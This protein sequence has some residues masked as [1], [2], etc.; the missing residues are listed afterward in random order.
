MIERANNRAGNGELVNCDDCAGLVVTLANLLG[1]DLYEQTVLT[2]AM[3]PVIPIGEGQWWAHGLGFLPASGPTGVGV[4]TYHRVAWRGSNENDALVFDI[5]WLLNAFADPDNPEQPHPR[6]A[7]P[8]MRMESGSRSRA[9]W[10]I[11]GGSTR[12]SGGSW[13]P[14]YAAESADRAAD[15]RSN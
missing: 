5:T 14:G 2:S 7:A 13:E 8:G 6:S 4:L 11:S 12:P 10:T 3:H 1:C 15:S 9:R